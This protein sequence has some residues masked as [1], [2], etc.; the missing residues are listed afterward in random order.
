[1]KIKVS[2]LTG[3]A[4]DWAVTRCLHLE[5]AMSATHVWLPCGHDDEDDFLIAKC[6]TD[7]ATIIDKEIDQVSRVDTY[8]H[9]KADRFACDDW[10]DCS[11]TGPTL[12]IA[13][14]RC[15]IT[16]KLG[17]VVEVPDSLA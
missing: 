5:A 8:P 12:L 16:A 10:E 13:A 1:M 3:A 7:W 2:E 6:S 14:M 4:L 9:W 17:G 15:Y 11:A